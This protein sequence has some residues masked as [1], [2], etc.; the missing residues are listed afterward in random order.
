MVKATVTANHLL[1][2]DDS[3]TE[4]L[5]DVVH[6]FGLGDNDSYN[7]T[8]KELRECISRAAYLQEK[9][10]ADS[11]KYKAWSE[12]FIAGFGWSVETISELFLEAHLKGESHDCMGPVSRT[13]NAKLWRNK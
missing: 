6:E 2:S 10:G 9:W 1:N 11:E 5:W 7:G 4:L 8:S 12:G 3:L 13:R